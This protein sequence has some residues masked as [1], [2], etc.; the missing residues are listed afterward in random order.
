MHSYLQHVK[1]YI[2]NLRDCKISVFPGEMLRFRGQIKL[3]VISYKLTRVRYKV[4][5][6]SKDG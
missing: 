4:E 5:G 3:R 1:L 6:E 2:C